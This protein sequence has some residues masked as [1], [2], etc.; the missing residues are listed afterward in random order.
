MRLLAAIGLDLLLFLGGYASLVLL[1]VD[2]FI[3]AFG[4]LI[5]AGPF[6]HLLVARAMGITVV[7][8]SSR[9]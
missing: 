9:R 6:V 1:G 3:A 4:V 8:K 5:L 2:P 7:G